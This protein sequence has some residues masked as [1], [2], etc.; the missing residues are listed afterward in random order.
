MHIVPRK[1]IKFC[2]GTD[3]YID[4]LFKKHG[5]D[6]WIY[7]EVEREMEEEKEAGIGEPP[8]T[9]NQMMQGAIDN[10]IAKQDLGK[11]GKEP[12]LDNAKNGGRTEA[13]EINIKKAKI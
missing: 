4:D 12:N 8:E 9:Q 2:V 5:E 13:P 3:R 11:N 6:W 10:E 1:G 7:A